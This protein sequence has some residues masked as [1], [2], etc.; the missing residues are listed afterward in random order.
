MEILNRYSF[1]IPSNLSDE[2]TE[3]SEKALNEFC[4]YFVNIVKSFNKKHNYKFKQDGLNFEVSFTL[5]SK[6]MPFAPMDLILSMPDFFVDDRLNIKESLLPIMQ[7]VKGKQLV[8]DIWR[9]LKMPTTESIMEL[10]ENE[11]GN[12]YRDFEIEEPE[13][14]D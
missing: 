10:L 4:A 9:S 2:Q 8:R 13:Y 7:S 14:E 5:T 11:M 1:S 6:G 3:L 12:F